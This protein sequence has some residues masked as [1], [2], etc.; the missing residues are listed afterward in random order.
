M[1]ESAVTACRGPCQIL[2]RSRSR[3]PHIAA[4]VA[5]RCAMAI[6][7]RLPAYPGLGWRSITW[8]ARA[9]SVG[10]RKRWADDLRPRAPRASRARCG[11]TALLKKGEAAAE[12]RV[13]LRT[14]ER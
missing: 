13:S 1:A 9:A 7:A 10:W 12:L 5:A 3:S 2:A 6:L 14:F 4:H 11:M 8:S